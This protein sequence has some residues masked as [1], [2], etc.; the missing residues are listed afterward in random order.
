[1]PCI[2]GWFCQVIS[3]HQNPVGASTWAADF[4]TLL[5][6]YP[7][8]ADKFA[9]TALVCD[10]RAQSLMWQASSASRALR[11]WPLTLCW[12]MFCRADPV[13]R[14]MRSGLG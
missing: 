7:L 8:D 11:D 2:G 4:Q 5:P 9:V 3:C 1:M 6:I 12:V 10:G 14:K 13:F